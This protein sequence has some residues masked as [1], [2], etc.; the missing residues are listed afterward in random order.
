LGDIKNMPNNKLIEIMDELTNEF[1]SV[2][3]NI[4]I[5]THYL[6]KIEE[7]YD[8]SLDEYQNRNNETK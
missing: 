5:S 1:E 8:K 7:L 2:K 6:D 4:I 3:N